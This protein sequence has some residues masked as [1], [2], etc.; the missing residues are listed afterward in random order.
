MGKYPNKIEEIERI[1]KV[2][3]KG[4]MNKLK[5]VKVDIF[6]QSA[7][8]TAHLFDLKTAKPNISNFKDF[9]RTLLE[10]IVQFFWQKNQVQ[11]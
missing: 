1:R 10:W 3:T 4:K 8:G 2:C 7:D 11:R 5:T 9:K 6:V